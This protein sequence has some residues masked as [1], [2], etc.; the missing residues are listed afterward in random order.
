MHMEAGRQGKRFF[1]RQVG[2]GRSSQSHERERRRVRHF[3]PR[4]DGDGAVARVAQDRGSL[5]R[6]RISPA[7]AAAARRA[8]AASGA[9]TRP[10]A[11]PAAPSSGDI[12]AAPPS[13]RRRRRRR[14]PARR[15]R[16]RPARPASRRRRPRRRAPRR[17]RGRRATCVFLFC[18]RA[19][20]ARANFWLSALLTR[21]E[22][23]AR[24][25][26]GIF[27]TPKLTSNPTVRRS[28]RGADVVACPS[29]RVTDPRTASRQ[30]L[31]Q[32]L[33]AC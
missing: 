23:S 2:R 3:R 26:S 28:A 10:R 15:R 30:K 24:W 29:D 19:S 20:P 18:G 1:T 14:S 17:S 4:R 8:G 31:V 5:S 16:S 25:R 21:I 33:F 6:K 12:G 27:H 13:P 22:D 11:S 32:K 7:A 9:C